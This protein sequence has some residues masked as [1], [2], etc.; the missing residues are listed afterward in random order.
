MAVVV[1]LD[2]AT[3]ALADV[4]PPGDVRTELT[5]DELLYNE[6]LVQ[7]PVHNAWFMPVGETGPALHEFSGTISF[8]PT[9]VKWFDGDGE[10][11][12]WMPRFE[13]SFV[14]HDDYLL[15]VNP[16]FTPTDDIEF[17][18]KLVVSPGHVW[19]EPTDNGLSRA[20]FP[21]VQ[22][23]PNWG[24]GYNGIMTFVFDDEMVSDVQVQI[25]QETAGGYEFTLFGRLGATYT[26]HAVGDREAIVADFEQDLAARLPVRPFANLEDSLSSRGRGAFAGVRHSEL[27]SSSGIIMDGEI[28][29][30][31]A[32]MGQI[33]GIS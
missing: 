2:V 11:E 24:E 5:A 14:V 9:Q 7:Q 26:P 25:V 1:V 10:H 3:H 28:C 32:P 15:P 16:G 13:L 20:S 12:D 17:G 27:I 21:F 31:S 22:A 19:S 6:I 33:R 30:T 29:L 4:E 8:Q 18:T 23:Y